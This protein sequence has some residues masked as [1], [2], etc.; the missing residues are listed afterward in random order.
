MIKVGR[1]CIAIALNT[2]DK[3]LIIKIRNFFDINMELDVDPYSIYKIASKDIDLFKWVIS[4]V[5]GE[6][7][8]NQFIPPKLVT[9]VALSDN[10]EALSI[11][12]SM[13]GVF[14]ENLCTLVSSR[15]LLN[16][17]IYMVEICHQDFDREMCILFAKK[18][19]GI[20]DYILSIT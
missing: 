6:N 4:Y 5:Y 1:M 13:G 19:S 17:F 9:Y 18:G 14:E 3:D 12:L 8:N 15:G 2:C 11:I 16:I 10:L 7:E 20:R